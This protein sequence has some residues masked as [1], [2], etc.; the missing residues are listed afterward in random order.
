MF[1]FYLAFKFPF[2]IVYFSFCNTVRGFQLFQILWFYPAFPH[3]SIFEGGDISLDR[4]VFLLIFFEFLGLTS[5]SNGSSIAAPWGAA[6]KTVSGNT[7]LR[8][9]YK[10]VASIFFNKILTRLYLQ[11][12]FEKFR[13]CCTGKEHIPSYISRLYLLPISLS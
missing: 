2:Y 6:K 12:R 4:S 10:P 5:A 13:Q 9:R 1:R 3:V 7:F 11:I 8:T